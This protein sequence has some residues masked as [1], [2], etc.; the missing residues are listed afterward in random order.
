MCFCRFS[1]NL[2]P[3]E[4]TSCPTMGCDFLILSKGRYDETFA[5][6]DGE[7]NDINETWL[8]WVS[9][10]N[11]SVLQ[12][13]VRNRKLFFLF[14]NQNIYAKNIWCVLKTTVSIIR[15]F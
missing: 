9:G 13:R 3:S 15:F 11:S 1:L 4:P 7:P 14:L 12:I 2:S 10:G 8:I 6:E 5:G